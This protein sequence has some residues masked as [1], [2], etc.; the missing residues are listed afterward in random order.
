[1]RWKN[2]MWGLSHRIVKLFA[3]LPY[4]I[5]DETRWLETV[6]ILEKKTPTFH[7]WRCVGWAT[8]EEYILFRND[9]REREEK[10]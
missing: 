10:E 4:S 7:Y 1:M 8:K 3:F 2:R 9:L 6:Y 5:G